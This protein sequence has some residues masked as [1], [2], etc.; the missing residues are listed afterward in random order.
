VLN[1]RPDARNHC[2][3][4]TRFGDAFGFLWRVLGNDVDVVRKLNQRLVSFTLFIKGL[5]QD[6]RGLLV[7][8]Q[9]GISTNTSVA[10][11][12]IMLHTLGRG[13]QRGVLNFW[14]SLFLDYFLSFLDQPLHRFAFLSSGCDVELSTNFL[15]TVCFKCFWKPC[16]RVVDVAAF[17]ILGIA[18]NN[19]VS[20]L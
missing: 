5:L 3:G 4:W 7:P 9:L 14:L 13:D 18:F 19:W 11:D 16:F 8:Q 15:Q 10:G 17:A 1:L 20:A 6:T 12:F 2:F